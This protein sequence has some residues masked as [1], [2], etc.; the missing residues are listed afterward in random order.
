MVS[1]G[2]SLLKDNLFEKFRYMILMATAFVLAAIACHY[3][4]LMPWYFLFGMF[5]Y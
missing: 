1:I 3:G 5:E 2:D 4:K